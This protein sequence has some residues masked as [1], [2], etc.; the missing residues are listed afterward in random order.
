[1]MTPFPFLILLNCICICI[2]RFK[3]VLYVQIR[4]IVGKEM[5]IFKRLNIAK[6]RPIICIF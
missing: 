5:A 6:S 2:V 1:M 3:L 4:V